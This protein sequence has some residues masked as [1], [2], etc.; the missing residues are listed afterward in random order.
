MSSIHPSSIVSAKA[1]LGTNVAVGPFCVVEDDVVIGDDCVIESH[2]A[3]LGGT[4]MGKNNRIAAGTIIGGAPQDRKYAGEPTFLEIGDDN[5]IREY[6]TLH[7]ATGEG[8]S[9]TIG[10]RNYLMAFVHV[11]HNCALMDDITI[12]NNVGCSGHVTIENNV[13]VGGMTGL[14]QWVR[15][16]RA[17]MVG[18]MSRIVRDVPPFMVVEG[19]DQR[20]VDINAVGLRRMGVTQEGRLALHKAAKLLF[21]SS[22]NL[23]NAIEIVQ[24][25]VKITPEVEELVAFLERLFHGKMGRGDQR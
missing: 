19:S 9:T 15:V 21:K 10:N 6:V 18:G 23:T 3:V 4:R 12:A 22:L 8:N 2:A 24:R 5:V 13:T 25:E 1:E 17:A 14:H 20:V 7:R 11:G 16:G